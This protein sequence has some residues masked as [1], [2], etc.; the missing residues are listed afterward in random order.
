MSPNLSYDSFSKS[1]RSNRFNMDLDMKDTRINDRNTS[2]KPYKMSLCI[3]T[4]SW[5]VQLLGDI[6]LINR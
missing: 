3:D 1:F 6:L 2:S 4:F 5:T